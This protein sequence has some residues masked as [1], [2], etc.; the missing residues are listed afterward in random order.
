MTAL[1]SADEREGAQRVAVRAPANN[2]HPHAGTN[3]LEE[4]AGFNFQLRSRACLQSLG[5]LLLA[6]GAAQKQHLIALRFL[7]CA[8]TQF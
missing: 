3:S 7:A 4:A 5:A 8:Y 6:V 1:D 2:C